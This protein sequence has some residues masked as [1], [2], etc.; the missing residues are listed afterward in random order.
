MRPW[1]LKISD[2]V[3]IQHNIP[4]YVFP[5]PKHNMGFRMCFSWGDP[6]NAGSMSVAWVPE[7]MLTLLII[8]KL[9][10]IAYFAN[11]YT[12]YSILIRRIM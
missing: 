2:G 8:F 3:K 1:P 6:D 7:E 10:K 11:K 4:Y 5:A 9:S 12:V